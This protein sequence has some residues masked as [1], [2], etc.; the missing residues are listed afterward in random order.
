M[1]NTNDIIFRKRHKKYASFWFLLLDT[2]GLSLKYIFGVVGIG[3]LWD[4]IFGV[5][6]Y[7]E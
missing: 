7:L 5:C 2:L 3:D 1:K 4:H 6:I